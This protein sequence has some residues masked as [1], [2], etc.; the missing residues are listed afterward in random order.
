M[1]TR[2][3]KIIILLKTIA[4]KPKFAM[5][6]VSKW[7]RVFRLKFISGNFFHLI[8][9]TYTTCNYVNFQVKL[10]KGYTSNTGK[11]FGGKSGICRWASFPNCSRYFKRPG[12]A[13]AVWPY[14]RFAFVPWTH[15]RLSKRHRLVDQCASRRDHERLSSVED[16]SW[17]HFTAKCRRCYN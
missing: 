9:K 13:K 16:F 3:V 8:K 10:S 15:G 17:S 14:C 1:A 2:R 7:R 12:W 4:P 6:P 11:I 5:P